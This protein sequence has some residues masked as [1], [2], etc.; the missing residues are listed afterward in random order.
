MTARGADVDGDGIKEEAQ[1]VIADRT[2]ILKAKGNP[3]HHQKRP[4]I[5][6][7]FYPV[8][9]EWYGIGLVE[10]V[11]SEV[12]E[13]NTLRRQRLDNINQVLNAMWQADPTA[14]V[15]L[16]T[17]ISAPN[18]IIL[19]SPLDAVKRLETP[20]V[21]ENAFSE[22]AIVQSDIEKATTPASVQGTPDSG[23]LGRTARGAQLIIGQALEKFGTATKLL[24]EQAIRPL[25]QR[26]HQ[27]NLQFI[28]SDDV[29]QSP[30]LYQEIAALQLR[31]EDIRAD[32]QFK[33]QGISDLISTEAKVNQLISFLSISG[34][35][36]A[37]DSLGNITKKIYKLMGFDPNEINLQGA[38]VPAGTQNVVDPAVGEAIAGQATNQGAAS[39]PPSIPQP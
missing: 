33:M 27:L 26:F 7:T 17:L 32:V 30:L 22:A 3:F 8:P 29:L 25:L 35:V 6:S 16:D 23:R 18:N 37:P 20:N 15:E 13:L 9:L 24:E 4:L 11:M 34:K 10:P 38:Q 5:R 28:S 12:H 36:L 31:P 21:T 2:V 39:A 19:S 14:D 1:I